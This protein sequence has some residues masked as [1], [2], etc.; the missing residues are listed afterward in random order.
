MLL[1][2]HLAAAQTVGGSLLLINTRHIL[3]GNQYGKNTNN[4]HSPSRT[5]WNLFKKFLMEGYFHMKRHMHAVVRIG[6]GCTAR[7]L[8]KQK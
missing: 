7:V 2:S 4:H 5:F 6:D 1:G 8:Q 3:G